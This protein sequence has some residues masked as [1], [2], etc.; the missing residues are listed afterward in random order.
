MNITLRPYQ[1]T[2]ITQIREA[3]WRVGR[4]LL[5]SPTGS[6]KTI[7]F[8]WLTIAILAHGARVLLLG[9]RQEIVDQIAALAAFDIKHGLIAP[10]HPP[11]SI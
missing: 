8:Y 1:E 4:V 9:H 10:G 3:L 11:G 5:V 7:L 2:A 6:G